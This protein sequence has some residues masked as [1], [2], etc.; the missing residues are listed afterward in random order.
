MLE[1]DLVLLFTRPLDALGISYMVTGSV[2]GILYGEPRVTHDVD[3]VVE[4][5]RRLAA[6]LVASFTPAEFYVP[7]EEV[8]L[9]ELTRERHGHFNLIH[10]KSGFKADIYLVGEDP[11]HPWGL[12]RRVRLK[13]GDTTLAVAPVEYVVV[14]KLQFFTEGGSEKHLR[15]IVGMLSINPTLEH[16]ADL[17]AWVQKLRLGD[18]WQAVLARR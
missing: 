13:L 9:V 5:P 10:H 17:A 18:A 11:L 2:A 16:S 4:L 6:S 3:V 7:P 8:V 14:R 15:D 12:A 1:P